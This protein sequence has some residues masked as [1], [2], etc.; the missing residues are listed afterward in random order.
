[1]GFLF[2]AITLPIAITGAFILNQLWTQL[3]FFFIGILTRLGLYKHPPPLHESD[4]D[5]DSGDDYIFILDG[6]CPSLVP[7]PIHVVTAAIKIK[8]PVLQFQDF[9]LAAPKN[10]HHKEDAQALISSCIICLE[11]ID[12]KHQVRKLCRCTHVFHRDCLDTWVDSGQV[13]CPLCR[14]MLLPPNTNLSRSPPPTTT[15]T[16]E[17]RNAN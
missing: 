9:L 12:L 10:T 8:L 6:T 2:H 14:S 7:I 16:V 15:V 3:K 13:T 17:D 4:D 1:M 5:D 11:G